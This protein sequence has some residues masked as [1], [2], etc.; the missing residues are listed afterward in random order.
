MDIED[1]TSAYDE[2]WLKSMVNWDM[3]MVY[4]QYHTPADYYH[5]GIK[6]SIAYAP[7][8]AA[9]ANQS[10]NNLVADN[11]NTGAITAHWITE[12]ALQTHQ[13]N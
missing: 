10:V 8:T 5:F 4:I 11:A 1:Q 3:L 6:G 12:G 2:A 7:S 9:D 13:V